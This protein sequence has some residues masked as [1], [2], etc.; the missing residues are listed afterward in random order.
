MLSLLK[1]SIKGDKAIWIIVL[2][3]SLIS[4]LTVFSAT[5]ALAFKTKGGNT[6]FYVIKHS[7]F[8][9]IGL[10][11]IWIIHR[12]PYS[13]YSKF[14][15]VLLVIA[16]PLLV[17]T[18]AMG[19]NLNQASRWLSIPGVGLTFQTSDLAKLAL[20]MYLARTMSN[21]QDVIKDFKKGFLPLIIPVL[22]VAGL[23]LPANFSTA[24]L[25]MLISVLLIFIGRVKFS[26][27]LFLVTVGTIALSIFIAIVLYSGIPGRVETWKKRIENYWEGDE[28]GNYQA[29]QAKIAVATGGIVGKGLGNSVQRNYLPHPYSD[30]IYATI[31]EEY[32]LLGS[33]FLLLLYLALLY[34]IGKIVRK[35]KYAFQAFLAI[36]LGLN[37]VLQAFVNMAVSVN[38]IPVTGQTLPMVSMGGTSIL[39]TS[40]AMGII[41]NISRLANEE[42]QI[43]KEIVT[44][45]GD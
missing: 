25:I 28:E 2:I 42:Q 24:A 33:G 21:K 40:V 44:P 26:H 18:L 1:N 15:V 41:L 17:L 34:R 45:D 5:D 3:L 14:S 37:F 4:V 11:F 27:I 12:I 6:A 20:I 7:G 23:I 38:L 31:V 43:E 9:L 39:F 19:T 16:I 32:G 35:S 8:I 30:F 13:W 36:G 10:F 29:E 22:I